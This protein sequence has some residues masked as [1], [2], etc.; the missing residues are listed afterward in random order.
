MRKRKEYP[1]THSMSTAWFGVDEDGNVA[2]LSFD[3]NGP[4]PS[5]IPES[6]AYEVVFDPTAGRSGPNST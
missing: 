4:V 5:Y 1:A 3:E 2:I 6:C